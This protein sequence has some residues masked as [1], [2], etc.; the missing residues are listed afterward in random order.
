MKISLSWLKDYLPTDLSIEEISLLLTDIGLEV[1]NIEEINKIPG[2]LKGL[3][4]GYVQKCIKHPNA[5][6]LSLTEIDLGTDKTLSIVCG[7][8]NIRQG[9][10]V[11]VAPAGTLIFPT[12]KDPITIQKGKIRGE[13]SEGMICSED[14]I[15]LGSSHD[16]IVILPEDAP[17]GA[18]VSEY[19][20][21]QGEVV[22]EI[23]LT[24]NRSDA[25]NHIGVAKDLN[26]AIQVRYGK[27]DE[28][29]LPDIGDFKIHQNTHPIE[30]IV[31]DSTACP[32]YA[33][34]TITGIKIEE[35]PEWLKNKLVSIGLRPINN[36]VDIT[37][38]I[39]HESGQP[40]H[41]FDLDKIKGNKINVTTL[42][43]DTEF[44]ALDETKKKLH[45]EDLM[46]CD[47]EGNPM[48]MGGVFGGFDSGVNENTTSIFLESAHFNS[49]KIRK[50]SMRHQW[51]TDAAKIFEKG[52]DPNQVIWSL[53][54]AAMLICDLTGG[55]ISSEIVDKYPTPVEPRKIDVGL[56][57]IQRLIGIEIPT[58]S[59]EKIFQ[60][61]EIKIL[62][63][64]K[65][66]WLVE[67][68]TNKVDVTREA[69]VIEEILRI[70]G[71][72]Q[73]PIPDSMQISTGSRNENKES[74]KK[75]EI[76]NLLVGMGFTEIMSL[77]LSE[78]KKFSGPFYSENE[79]VFIHNTSNI[80]LNIM[81]PDLAGSM[82]EVIVHNQNRQNSDLKLFEFGRNY[83]LKGG[84]IEERNHFTIALSG[85]IWQESWLSPTVQ[86]ETGFYYLKTIFFELLNKCGIVDF[87]M[88]ET[89]NPLFT[90]GLIVKKNG[91]LLGE[92]GKVSDNFGIKVPVFL[93]DLEWDEIFKL[94]LQ[95]EV[96]YSPINKFPGS[97]R[98]LALVVD[99]SVKFSDIALIAEKLGKKLLKS[100]NLFDVYIQKEQ[101]G[102]NKKS[103]AVSFF[104]EDPDRTLLDKDLD[105][106]MNLLIQ[107]YEK[108]LNA[109]IR[110]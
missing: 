44:I 60:A 110:R 51:R 97:R 32:R 50:S 5:D 34:L 15:G 40:L 67:I 77:S 85:R 71:F 106:I 95:N 35:S 52:S 75:E 99:N 84:G 53:K 21:L 83:H 90:Y 87:Q 1:E 23:G 4:I 89:S 78:S 16:G 42:P 81:R 76:S 74:V 46:I 11:I 30:V 55:K 98:D 27:K 39:L 33:G 28:L 63:K 56:K 36:V 49:S 101:L 79:L 14:E 6:R 105:E 69:D 93:G 22:I 108:Q 72:N 19:L 18:S 68:P 62:T 17:I 102:E 7:A 94:W 103:Y 37:N 43:Q 54:R 3:V 8:N 96:K 13:L 12:G 25:T 80:H 2:G 88:E 9:Q 82:L 61:L 92:I 38:F 86:N 70:Y 10:K 65:D 26:A 41:A 109:K 57:N 58:F 59:L 100:L 104:F 45:S 31:S 66:Q 20:K 91:V 64:D 73:I 29:R 48:C 107:E 24:P 47:G